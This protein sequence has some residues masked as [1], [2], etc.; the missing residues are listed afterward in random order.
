MSGWTYILSCADS[1]Y[2]VGSTSYD[3]VEKRVGEHNDGRLPGYTHSRRVV[4]LAWAE[5]FEDIRDAQDF[6]R[7]IKKWRREKK[8][9]LIRHDRAA[10]PVLARRTKRAPPFE[11]A[12]RSARLRTS[13]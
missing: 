1:G 10:L 8:E 6:E 4:E 13:G 12:P 11:A 3:D 5:K 2:Y 7:Q 9:A